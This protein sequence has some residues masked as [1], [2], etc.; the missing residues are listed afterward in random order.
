VYDLK[1]YLNNLNMTNGKA[2][3][4]V[5]AGFVA[6]A[7]LGV[8]FAPDKGSEVRKKIAKKGDDLA[9]ALGN[10]IHTKFEKVV[11]TITGKTKKDVLPKENMAEQ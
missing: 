3:L 4:A 6:G 11:D 5:L 8:L 7:A 2:V 10:K 9:D 1:K